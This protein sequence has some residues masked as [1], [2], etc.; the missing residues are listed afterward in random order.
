MRRAIIAKPSAGMSPWIGKFVAYGGLPSETG[1]ALFR[2]VK[3]D[4]LTV[5]DLVQ[6]LVD[7]DEAAMGWQHLDQENFT[8]PPRAANGERGGGPISTALSAVL[9]DS[10]TAVDCDHMVACQY[11]VDFV[12]VLNDSSNLIEIYEL[13]L[14]GEPFHSNVGQPHA[15]GTYEKI[16]EVGF[17]GDEPD[18]SQWDG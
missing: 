7:S 10:T 6:L 1:A 4:G 9:G 11:A 14:Q 3:T 12:Y 15:N 18:W 5:P 16:A 2:A 17:D 13:H 8:E